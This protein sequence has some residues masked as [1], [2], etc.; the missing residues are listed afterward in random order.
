MKR[1]AERSEGALA[2][3]R[4]LPAGG[5]V[6][7][8]RALGVS[9]GQLSKILAGTKQASPEFQ[10]KA[11]ELYSVPL[12]DWGRAAGA[13]GVAATDPARPRAP[14]PP[15]PDAA[16]AG[17]VASVRAK[18]AR[19]EAMVQDLLDAVGAD[20][21]TPLEQARVMA[22]A[23]STL[24]LLGKLTGEVLELSERQILRSPAW[25]RVEGA[26]LEALGDHP[27]ALEAVVGALARLEEGSR[28]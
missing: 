15:A 5:Q 23:A 1:P 19:M 14:R 17:T 7:A 22:S 13:V 9:Q 4:R 26:V 20:G 12:E 21:S 10:R 16:E 2:L 18:A 25:R 27:A 8:A 24:A 6:A 11:L 3:R 28:A